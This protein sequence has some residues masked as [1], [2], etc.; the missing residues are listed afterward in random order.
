[1][2]NWSPA[3]SNFF[4]IPKG[5]VSKDHPRFQALLEEWRMGGDEA[6]PVGYRIDPL[7]E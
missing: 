7:Q 6:A 2:T 5:T 4:L 1:M 3:R